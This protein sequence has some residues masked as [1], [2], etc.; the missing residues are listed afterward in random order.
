MAIGS[1]ISGVI[2]LSEVPDKLKE[3]ASFALEA[4]ETY[5]DGEKAREQARALEEIDI[6]GREIAE[7]KT[8]DALIVEELARYMNRFA[9]GVKPD[10]DI[11]PEAYR[12]AFAEEFLSLNP[13]IRGYQNEV[14]E[15]IRRWFVELE[16][17]L[18]DSY[19]PGERVLLRHEILNR[20]DMDE[21]K[22][23][24]EK[25]LA[26]LPDDQPPET[27]QSNNKLYRA[28]FEEPLFLHNGRGGRKRND[29]VNLSNLFVHHRFKVEIDRAAKWNG[30]KKRLTIILRN[31]SVQARNF[32]LS[33][34]QPD[35]ERAV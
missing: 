19:S 8:G 23:Y 35:A 24:L 3:I 14:R 25:I 17:A 9:G 7:S 4:L 27:L 34:A 20:M 28:S 2:S 26:R 21:I 11:F 5:Q 32:C 6:A 1:L 33:K 13:R 12:K 18:R 16:N 15:T 22:R 29:K 31:L 10:G 30:P